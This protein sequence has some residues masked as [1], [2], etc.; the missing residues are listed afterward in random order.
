[1]FPH[2]FGN[3]PRAKRVGEWG[4]SNRISQLRGFEKETLCISN[5]E[6]PKGHSIQPSGRIEENPDRVVIA[7][8]ES[9]REV[10]F[11][12]LMSHAGCG[13]RVAQRLRTC[14]D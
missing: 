1:M 4:P 8:D 13:Q 2:L 3:A 7:V 5:F 12:G 6:A 14:I 10:T 11:M 9:V